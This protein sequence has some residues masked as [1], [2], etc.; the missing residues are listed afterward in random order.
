MGYRHP[1]G[2]ASSCPYA[3]ESYADSAL[4]VIR[5]LERREANLKEQTREILINKGIRTYRDSQGDYLAMA[6]M[7][8]W[9]LTLIPS[10]VADKGKRK[11]G[12]I[13]DLCGCAAK[14]SAGRRESC[15]CRIDTI[16]A[17]CDANGLTMHHDDYGA[18][19]RVSGHYDI[20]AMK[21]RIRELLK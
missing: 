14:R 3:D 2:R 17:Y 1:R 5:E 21:R 18:W 20:P 6:L 9:E 10:F 4:L 7:I 15:R 12:R 16:K 11:Q 19:T 13:V 8:E